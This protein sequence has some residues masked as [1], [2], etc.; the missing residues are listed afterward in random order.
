VGG[1]NTLLGVVAVNA[2]LTKAQASKMA[3]M[4]QDAVARCVR[5]AHTMW[6]GD[7]VFALATGGPRAEVSILGAFAAEALTAAI[8]QAVRSAASVGGL[9]GLLETP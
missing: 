2:E 8:L 3:Q 7:T 1:S 4:A 5:P 6:D 9:P